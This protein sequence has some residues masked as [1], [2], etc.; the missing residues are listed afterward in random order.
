MGADSAGVGGYAIERRKDSKV[1]IN[2][3]FLIGFTSSFRMGQL[4]RFKFTPPKMT[5][6]QDVYEFMVSDFVEGVRQCLKN[7]GYSKV[8]SNEETGGTFLVGYRGRLFTVESDFQVGEVF[9]D[10]ASVGCG[11]DIALGSMFS[12]KSLPQSER[13]MMAL[14]AAEDYS[15]GVRGPFNLLTIG[16]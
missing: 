13:I 5:E 6:G 10:F 12:T 1:F 4:L 15:A 9:G 11:Q 2:G 8:S 3:E 14:Q 7:G 16:G